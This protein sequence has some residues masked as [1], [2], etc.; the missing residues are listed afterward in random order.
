[1]ISGLKVN[2]EE[3]KVL[4]VGSAKERGPIQYDK[5]DISWVKG[6]DFALGVW[7]VADRNVMLRSNYDERITKIKSVIEL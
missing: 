7:F 5:P 4:W 6:K 3:T 1:M 2:F